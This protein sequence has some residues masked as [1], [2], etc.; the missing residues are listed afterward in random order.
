MNATLC[1]EMYLFKKINVFVDILK[2][3]Y[4]DL[5]SGLYKWKTVMSEDNIV[6]IAKLVEVS[7]KFQKLKVNKPSDTLSNHLRLP[8]VNKDCHFH[9]ISSSCFLH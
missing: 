4:L 6:L 9:F 8:K 5:L 1:L 3:N 7:E 2:I